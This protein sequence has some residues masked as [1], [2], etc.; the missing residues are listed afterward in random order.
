[1]LLFVNRI[2]YFRVKPEAK[3]SND[4]TDGENV[5]LCKAALTVA[6]VFRVMIVKAFQNRPAPS[7]RES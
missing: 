6:Y 3:T 7:R 1:M 4:S 5:S 2:H